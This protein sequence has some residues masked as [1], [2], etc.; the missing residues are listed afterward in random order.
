MQL[1]KVILWGSLYCSLA[2]HT[3]R[4]PMQSEIVISENYSLRFCCFSP[5]VSTQWACF[6]AWNHPSYPEKESVPEEWW[7]AVHVCHAGSASHRPRSVGMDAATQTLWNIGQLVSLISLFGRVF[8]ALLFEDMG[9]Y[10]YLC[11]LCNSWALF[12]RL[13]S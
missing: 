7:F 1:D 10:L 4:L 5:T 11:S 12:C 9:G 8:G 2:L 6:S 3:H 13:L